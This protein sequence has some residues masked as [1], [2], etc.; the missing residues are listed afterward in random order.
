MAGIAGLVDL[1]GSRP[2]PAGTVARMTRALAHRGPDGETVF[3]DAGVG[4]GQ[5]RLDFDG[6]PDV[7]DG[8]VR[9][10]FHGRLTNSQEPD[11]R[12]ILRLWEQHGEGLVEH[13]RGPFAFALWDGRQRTLLL[14]RD[15]VGCVPLYSAERDGWLL[16]GSEIKA[17]FASGLVRPEADRLGI[18][19]VFTF[20]GMPSFRTCFQGVTALLPGHTWRVRPGEASQPRRYW[21]LDFPDKG[22]ED[23]GT[24]EQ[25][26]DQLHDTLRTAVERRLRGGDLVASAVSGGIDCSTLVALAGKIRG[27]PLPTFTLRIESPELDETDR[28]QKAARASGSEPVVISCG[29]GDFAAGF[30]RFVK[31]LESPV[32]DPSC[33]ALMML[34]EKARVAGFKL[35]LSGDGADDL[36]AGYPWFKIDRVLR[37]LDFIP[38]LRPSQWI[39]RAFLWWN[40]RHVPWA[41][42]RKIQ[43]LVGGHHAWLDLYGLVSLSRSRFYSRTML[44]ALGGRF[45]HED[46]RLNLDRMKKWDPLNQALYL[47]MKVHIPGLQMLAKGD[48]GAMLSGVQLQT[49]FLDEDVIALSTRIPPGYKLRGLRDKYVLRKV[50]ERYLPK[51]IA[52]RPKVDFIAPFDSLYGPS[53]PPWVEQ[54]LSEESLRKTDYF[55]PAAVHHWRERYAKLRKRSTTR[56]SVEIGLASIVA[57]QLWHQTFIAGGLADLPGP[58]FP[59]DGYTP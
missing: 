34:A 15:R 31:A 12:L 30:P 33:V 7:P 45:A 10:A 39:R 5:R 56:L 37:S 26:A 53:A 27:K 35:M 14:A 42:V 21:D 52:W 44:D 16:F 38:G 9:I 57:T 29:T 11:P 55:D 58:F 4:L 32:P 49:P 48:R 3:E 43:S 23:G 24:V 54:L 47:G 18:D 6:P 59:E 51:E 36:F 25:C 40:A 50:A 46:L 8:P 1:T 20:L 41:N 22:Q 2:V 28:A 17:L 13:L 19:H